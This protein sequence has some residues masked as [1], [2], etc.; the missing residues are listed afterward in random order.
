MVSLR[1]R[2]DDEDVK[3]NSYMVNDLS[4]NYDLWGAYKVFFDVVNIFD[5]KYS[6][7]LQYSQMDRSINFGIR[8]SY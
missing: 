5:K 1:N 6:T 7:A 8:R 4:L 3:L 2:N